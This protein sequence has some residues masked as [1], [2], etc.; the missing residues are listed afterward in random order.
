M[1]ELQP[2]A[3]VNPNTSDVALV[4][5]QRNSDVLS[6]EE[7]RQYLGRADLTDEQITAIKNYLI[8]VVDGALTAYLDDFR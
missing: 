8:G 7:C 5:T 2:I 6:V 4:R 3:T 1:D